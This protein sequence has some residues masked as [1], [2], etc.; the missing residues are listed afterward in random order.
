MTGLTFRFYPGSEIQAAD[1]LVIAA[2]PSA[3]VAHRGHCCMFIENLALTDFNLKVPFVSAVIADPEAWTV[4][5]DGAI[6]T[7]TVDPDDGISLGYALEALAYSPYVNLA[8]ANAYSYG[9]RATADFITEGISERVDALIVAENVS[10]LDLINRFARLHFW[11]IVQRDKLMAIER[12]SVSPDI[13]LD[14]THIVAAGDAPPI[15]IERSG[16]SDRPRELEYSFIDI[17]RDYEINSVTAKQMSIPAPATASEGK[18][19]IAL[20]CRSY[21]Q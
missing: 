15:L 10:F 12:G 8:S 4:D 14:L 19:T 5:E 18:D 16:P 17:N 9:H 1:P 7:E 21:D 20:A 13:S 6:T 3:P 2:Y 11:D